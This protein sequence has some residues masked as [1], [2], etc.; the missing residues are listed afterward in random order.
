LIYSNQENAK[1]SLVIPNLVICFW[2]LFT[3]PGFLIWSWN[4]IDD[5]ATFKKSAL[6]RAFQI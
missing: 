5:K 4:K 1:S 3:I 2:I 6:Q